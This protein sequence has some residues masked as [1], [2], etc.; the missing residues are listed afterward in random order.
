MDVPDGSVID[1]VSMASTGALWSLSVT[2][3]TMLIGCPRGAA[4]DD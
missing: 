2:M 3:A 4:P 1:A